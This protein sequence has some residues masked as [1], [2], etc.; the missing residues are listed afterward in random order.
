MASSV[1][2]QTPTAVANLIK[3]QKN[4]KD[5]EKIYYAS[6]TD[7]GL[8]SKLQKN[9]NDVKIAEKALEA[10]KTYDDPLRRD[11]DK[12]IKSILESIGPHS[13]LDLTDKE[14]EI[15]HP[16]C[17]ILERTTKY[18]K[19]DKYVSSCIHTEKGKVVKCDCKQGPLSFLVFSE[20]TKEYADMNRLITNRGE[21]IDSNGNYTNSQTK[22]VVYKL[23]KGPTRPDILRLYFMREWTMETQDGKKKLVQTCTHFYDDIEIPCNCIKTK[24][25]YGFFNFTLSNEGEFGAHIDNGHYE[26]NLKDSTPIS[27]RRTW[28]LNPNTCT[29]QGSDVYT[30]K[31][32]HYG[33]IARID[34]NKCDC[35]IN[36]NNTLTLSQQMQK[37]QDAGLV[38]LTMPPQPDFNIGITIERRFA[39][40]LIPEPHCIL[41][42]FGT[43]RGGPVRCYHSYKN[44]TI[45][46]CDCPLKDGYYIFNHANQ[47][48][49]IS[50]DLK[51]KI[52]LGRKVDINNGSIAKILSMNFRGDVPNFGS[53]LCPLKST[54]PDQAYNHLKQMQI[55]LYD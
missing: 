22:D 48:F 2:K 42:G 23:P 29:P 36:P 17:L 7:N 20:K 3:A 43:G 12:Q 27:I 53:G 13:I 41:N 30:I 38:V 10:A 50:D 5:F 51:A 46:I 6:G 14:K 11:L 25:P 52:K 45:G 21:C 16:W 1:A 28:E 34:L 4:L 31:C 33:H 8:S 37:F 32:R 47:M 24:S 26:L 44:G 19:D 49:E 55:S 54:N 35:I 39:G 40:L 15:I 9:R 18:G